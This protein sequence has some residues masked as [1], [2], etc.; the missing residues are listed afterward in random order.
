M[1]DEFSVTAS[2][3][4]VNWS[5]QTVEDEV[6]QNVSVILA[7]QIGSVPYSRRLG[8]SISALDAPTPVA[9]ASVIREIIQKIN[10]FEPRAIIHE[11]SFVQPHQNE[12]NRLIPKLVIGV[13]K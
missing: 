8:I 12:N 11:V 1:A 7:T 3:F 4:K 13:K 6:I 5:P 2:N 10:E 9:M